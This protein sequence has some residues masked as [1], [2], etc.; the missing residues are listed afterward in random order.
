MGEGFIGLCW[1]CPGMIRT[2]DLW[3]MPPTRN[4]CQSHFLR[5]EAVSES[6]FAQVGSLKVADAGQRLADAGHVG[7][8]SGAR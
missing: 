2:H 4:R 3:G 6:T 7:N 8:V 5:S 1:G